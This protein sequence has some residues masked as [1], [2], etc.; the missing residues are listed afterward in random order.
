MNRQL[1]LLAV[2]IGSACAPAAATSTPVTKAREPLPVYTVDGRVLG[3]D[4]RHPPS[5]ETNVRL[6]LQPDG[7]API[8]VDLAPGWYLDQRGIHF[9]EQERLQV[10]GYREQRED[11]SRFVVRRVRRKDQVLEL[12]DEAGRPYWT[13]P[14]P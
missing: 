2:L 4:A 12:R 13:R 3:T 6:I 7:E 9:S 5:P 8:V 10:E 14:A 1:V 11:D